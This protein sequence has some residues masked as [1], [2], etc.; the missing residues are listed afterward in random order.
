MVAEDCL[1]QADASYDFQRNRV[2]NSIP[3]LNYD[4][5]V[6]ILFNCGSSSFENSRC[7]RKTIFE[8]LFEILL[9]DNKIEKSIR[10]RQEECARSY[11]RPVY[12]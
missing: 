11:V 5:F 2:R 9:R 4:A 10:E 6:S 1:I 7:A 12:R 8:V 3:L